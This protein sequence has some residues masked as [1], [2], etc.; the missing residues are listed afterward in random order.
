MTTLG[1]S[2][3]DIYASSMHA[4]YGFVL[5]TFFK[6]FFQ[7]IHF[8]KESIEELKQ[9]ESRGTVIYTLRSKSTLDY[10]VMN[11]KLR[12][13]GLKLSRLTNGVNMMLWKP[14]G[15]ALQIL[16]EKLKYLLRGKRMPDP[17]QSGFL[18]QAIQDRESCLMYL[19]RSTS[20][21]DK[22]S[23]PLWDPILELIH[24]QKKAE[25]PEI[26]LV[27]VVVVYVKA[28]EKTEKSVID[29][30]FGAKT[31]PGRLRKLVQFL[32]SY[33]NAFVTIGKSI[34]LKSFVAQNVQT[35]TRVLAKKVRWSLLNYL[36]R[37]TRV[38]FGP[39]A[40]SRERVITRVLRTLSESIQQH[41]QEENESPEKTE[42][43]VLKYLN[44]IVSDLDFRYVSAW[45]KILYFVWNKIYEGLIVDEKELAQVREALKDSSV[46]LI[47]SHKSHIDYLMLSYL[48]YIHHLIPPYIAAGQNLS[49]WPMGHIFRKSGAF[50]LR[51]SFKGLKLYPKV[52]QKYLRFLIKEGFPFEFFIEGGRS[53]SGKLLNP[54]TGMLRMILEA[55]SEGISRDLVFIP[56]A[57]TYEKIIEENAYTSES[58]GANKA[59]ENVKTAISAVRNVLKQNYGRVFL[60]FSEPIR[61]QDYLKQKNLSETS[62]LLQT[63]EL[64]DQFANQICDGINQKILIIPSALAAT[65]LLSHSKRGLLESQFLQ[66]TRLLKEYAS[67]KNH[68]L[69]FLDDFE[70][71]LKVS[72]QAFRT[73]NLIHHHF[74]ENQTV[75]VIRKFKKLHLDY[76]KNN[77]VHF[78]VAP[79]LC[80]LAIIPR[81]TSP[82]QLADLVPEERK[83]RQLLALEFHFFPE[84]TLENTLEFFTKVQILEKTDPHFS[85]K[86]P[87][88]LEFFSDLLKNF[89]ISYQLVL[90]YFEQYQTVDENDIPKLL[91]MG[92][93]QWEIGNIVRHEAISKENFKNA[94][95]WIHQQKRTLEFSAKEW[96]DYL[97][98]FIL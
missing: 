81:R 56:V 58:L 6:S 9:L 45:N 60:R 92:H 14:L 18:E 34:Q 40:Y 52:F 54:K 72:L 97:S 37:E 2:K 41:S 84:S 26:F 28:P 7:S 64:V 32:L 59:E 83:L 98:R 65:V 21:I 79:A 82:F 15:E 23:R 16:M 90:Q 80:A 47:P 87:E 50:F 19:K 44:E 85:V 57:I 36:Y 67:W 91:N 43:Q 12:E 38:I 25:T 93:L 30:V 49:F 20:Y 86:Q 94:I 46:V 29:F 42:K 1:D 55:Y 35:D 77:I 62:E 69:T 51:R 3:L 66:R 22:L 24:L 39:M 95:K 53:R 73:T 4:N 70:N 5:E 75:F 13:S 63:K 10:L 33:R 78:F 96:M 88:N 68:S 17:I 71:R 89:L 8:P 31:E 76:Y 61:F 27:P 74:Y 11:Y 48:F